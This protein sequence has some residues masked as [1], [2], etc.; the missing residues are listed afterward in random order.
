MKAAVLTLDGFEIQDVERPAI[1]PDEV[2]IKTQACGICSGDLFVYQNRQDY[3]QTYNRLGH[4]ASGEIIEVGRNVAEFKPGD[5]VT[6]L[7]LP[8]YSR[9][10]AAPAKRIVKLPSKVDPNIA[11]GEAVACCV[12]A[13]NRF[14]IKPGDKVAVIGL[15]F[16]GQICLQLAKYQGAGFICAIDPVAERYELS[17]QFGADTTFNPLKS[18][19]KE[20]LDTLGE[21]DVVIEAAG[22]QSA[23]DLSTEL[24]AIHGRIVLVGYHQSNNGMRTVNV[25]RWNY[26]AI[27]VVN[28]HVRNEDEKTEAMALGMQLIEQRHISTNKLVT[29]YDFD[30]IEQA[31]Q[32]LDGRKAGV[33]KAVLLM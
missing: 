32:D 10:F 25:E 1:A 4:E 14:Q 2:L 24:V 30:Q 16:M 13:A 28:G 26:K 8:A 12:H 23:I 3:Y 17:K 6:T 27:D 18:T 11:L 5:V 33:L 29:F 9:Y 22:V 31:F 15:G 20:I 7:A 19:G 21:F